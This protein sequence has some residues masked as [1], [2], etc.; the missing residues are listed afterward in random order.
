MD[1]GAAAERF[2]D[3]VEAEGAAGDSG[4]ERV[5]ETYG[6]VGAAKG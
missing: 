2:L 5:G 4:T 6:T 3:R 1:K